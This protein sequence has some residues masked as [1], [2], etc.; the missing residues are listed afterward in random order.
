MLVAL[1][2]LTG[3]DYTSKFGT[4]H[5]ALSCDPVKYLIDFGRKM[6][7]QSIEESVAL[8]EQYLDQL[9]KK[10]SHCQTMDELRLWTF[11]WNDKKKLED[12]PPTSRSTR[13]H[14]LRSIFCT[15]NQLTCLNEDREQLDA[16]SFGYSKNGDWLLPKKGIILYPDEDELVPNCSCVK[17]A[18]STCCCAAAGL[19][20]C[21]FCKCQ[22]V[23]VVN[24]KNEYTQQDFQ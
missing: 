11:Y 22:S 7:L 13:E 3:G 20:C 18:R 17:C 15:Y 21:V 23:T 8:A 9:L 19:S 14:I 12:M 6:D 24:C 4:K 16:T 2:T 10:G 1:H 5:A